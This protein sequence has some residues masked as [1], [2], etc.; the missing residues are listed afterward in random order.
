MCVLLYVCVVLC[1]CVCVCV[2][3]CACVR[4]CASVCVN[5]TVI[6][7]YS[8][9]CGTRRE[10]FTEGTDRDFDGSEYHFSNVLCRIQ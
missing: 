2:C 4:A 10:C 5:V 8:H 3:A 6:T 9:R 1:V 7:I